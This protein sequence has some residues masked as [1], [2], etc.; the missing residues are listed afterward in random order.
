MN[1]IILIDNPSYCYICESN[2]WDIEC[3]IC[4]I[5][6]VC[7]ECYNIC[8]YCKNIVCIECEKEIGC[9]CIEVKFS[10]INF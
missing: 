7:K 9:Q 3:N 10:K 6:K 8:K 2:D 5:N 4:E 1:N